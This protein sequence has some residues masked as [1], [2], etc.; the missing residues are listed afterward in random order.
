MTRNVYSNLTVIL[1]LLNPTIKTNWVLYIPWIHFILLFMFIIFKVLLCGWLE[2]WKPGQTLVVR[3]QQCGESR[4]LVKWESVINEVR[5]MVTMW[6][7][8]DNWVLTMCLSWFSLSLY[9]FYIHTHIYTIYKC[10]IY[11]I[12]TVLYIYVY[13]YIYLSVYWKNYHLMSHNN[14]RTLSG[15]LSCLFFLIMS[16]ISL[17]ISTSPPR[18]KNKPKRFLILPVLFHEY[19]RV[20]NNY[21]PQHSPRPP[22]KKPCHF[23]Y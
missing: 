22:Q 10:I 16:W 7:A 6:I 4:G 15:Y 3:C 17:P 2:I 20:E 1:Y 19:T 12:Y 5:I 21:A 11:T 18:I 14:S 8:N 23:T 9:M 13:L